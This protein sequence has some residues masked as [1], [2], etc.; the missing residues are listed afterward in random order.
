LIKITGVAQNYARKYTIPIDTVGFEFE[1]KADDREGMTKP[2]DGALIY[3]SFLI[4]I[5]IIIT[6]I[7]YFYYILF[8]L[9]FLFSLVMKKSCLQSCK[10][11]AYM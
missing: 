6:H 11:I 4:S 10:P 2:E 8:G 9:I 1:M 3:V 7:F 5:F